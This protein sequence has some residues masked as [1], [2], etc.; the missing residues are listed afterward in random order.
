MT[1]LV[2]HAG[3]EFADA[4]AVQ[5]HLV[6]WREPLQAADV[7]LPIGDS[8]TEWREAALGLVPGRDSTPAE[9]L[10]TRARETSASTILVSSDVLADVLI[11]PEETAGFVAM[12]AGLDLDVRVVVVV[13]EQIGYINS[14]Y[15]NR[16]R[17][18]ETARS[19]AAFATDPTPAHRFDY[20]ATFGAIADTDGVDL[21][22]IPYPELRSKQAGRAV[23]EAAGVSGD[24]I[25]GLPPVADQAEPTPGPV[26]IA[27]TRLLHKRLRKL[28]RVSERGRPLLRTLSEGLAARAT[29]QA[30]DSQTFWGWDTALRRSVELELAESN[31][32]FADF[33][34]GT[35]WPEPLSVARPRRHDLADLEPPVLHDVFATVERLVGN[36]RRT[37][38][39]TESEDQE[40]SEGSEGVRG[41]VDPPDFA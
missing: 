12:A 36:L 16:V 22:A 9:A 21:V 5:R 8:Q 20:V 40:E 13:R 33:V 23:L 10:L 24:V 2:V 39:P 30:W 3:T 37:S 34:W 27:A 32:M 14:L 29:E 15:C 1:R 11:S 26:L 28:G 6:A 31:E 19:F 35:P 41:P 4:G 18:L 38:P 25:D 17:N 7:V